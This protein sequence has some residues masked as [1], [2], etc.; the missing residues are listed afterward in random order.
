MQA[1]EDAVTLRARILAF[2]ARQN[3]PELSD[4]RIVRSLDDIEPKMLP[5]VVGFLREQWPA[6]SVRQR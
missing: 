2:L 5:F 6:G 3:P 4:I 1:R